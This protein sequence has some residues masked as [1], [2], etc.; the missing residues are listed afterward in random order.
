MSSLIDLIAERNQAYKEK[1]Y[2]KVIDICDVIIVQY[3]KEV[4]PDTYALKGI[5]LFNQQSYQAALDILVLASQSDR[6]TLSIGICYRQLGNDMK[7]IP[8]FEKVW[9][10]EDLKLKKYAKQAL[11]ILWLKHNKIDDIL[12]KLDINAQDENGDSLL[13]LATLLGYKNAISNLFQ[14][15]IHPYLK[16]KIQKDVFDMITDMND[17]IMGQHILEHMKCIIIPASDAKT[18]IKNTFQHNRSHIINQYGTEF[19]Q[20]HTKDDI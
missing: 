19:Y 4:L 2:Q 1:N 9:N 7:S 5:A 11:L 8:Y 3:P 20:Y 14:H 10:A 15:G 17:I 13:H 16:N 6:I 18:L 12:N